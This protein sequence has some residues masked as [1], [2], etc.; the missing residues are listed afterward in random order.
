MW[1]VLNRLRE[2]LVAASRKLAMI[3]GMGEQ[4]KL[5]AVCVKSIGIDVSPMD[6]APDEYGCAESMSKQM[7]KAFPELNFP[8]IT[9]TK[10]FY[11]YLTNSPSWREC[12][13]PAAMRLIISVTGTGNGVVKNGHVGLLGKNK[14]DADRSWWIMSNDSRTGTWEVNFTLSQ[15]QHFYDWKGGMQTHYFERV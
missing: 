15:W 7:Q 6:L 1:E 8:T 2:Q 3:R 9:S 4:E 14:S 5:Y 12:D 13:G 10:V 11:L